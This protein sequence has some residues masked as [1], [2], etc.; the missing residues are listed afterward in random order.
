MYLMKSIYKYAAAFIIG[1]VTAH[2][3]SAQNSY[4]GYFLDNYTYRTQ[5]NPAFATDRNYIGFPG[6]GNINMAMRGNI[7]LD[8]VLYN[9]DGQTVL[10]TNP[11]ISVDQVM[12]N[13]KDRNDLQNSIK[14]NILTTG[15][16]AMGGYNTISISAATNMSLNIPG[17]LFS[18]AK[19]GFSNKTYDISNMDVH[20]DAYAEIALGHSH[21]VAKGLRIGVTAKMLLGIGN[22][23]AYFNEANLTLGR[24]AWTA[25][26]NADV[27][28]S[29]KGLAYETKTN[30]K[31]GHEYVSG[32]KLD[33]FS[34]PSGFGVAFDL[35]LEYK[36]RDFSFSAAV[37]DLG[38][39]SWGNTMHASTNGTKTFNTNAFV[40]NIDDNAS[41]SIDDEFE[42]LTNDLS[43]LYELENNGNIGN[44]SRML[45][46]TV[47]A[48][49]EYKLPVYRKLS[50]GLLNT[51][52]ID[53]DYTWTQFRLGAN[54]AP[55][56]CFSASV[57]GAY[58][59]YGWA[60]GWVANVKTPGFN[61]FVGMDSTP[62]KLAKQGVPINSNIAINFGLNIAF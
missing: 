8:D 14:L 54:W 6:L 15:F 58:G 48:G 25:T 40:F 23:D 31:T 38:V 27:Y 46:T 41:N 12:A 2:S 53:G 59:T 36:Y 44:R 32:V 11:N 30:E 49:I 24:N 17:T 60:F 3:V 20:A 19:E 37:L 57:N 10:F 18:L 52:R 4:S 16:K 13:I 1:A 9:V 35:G 51:T 55:S 29:V 33:N 21:Q 22:V 50:F 26:T 34:A 39:I 62:F 5:L 61:L 43:K 28:S 45:A 7:G 56:R 42:K 47:N